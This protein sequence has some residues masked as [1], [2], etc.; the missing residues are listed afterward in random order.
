M[1]AGEETRPLTVEELRGLTEGRRYEVASMLTRG[2]QPQDP[3]QAVQAL[4]AAREA[5]A[6]ER[7]IF[8]E[9]RKLVLDRDSTGAPLR[10]GTYQ[11]TTALISHH[12][13]PKAWACVRSPEGPQHVVQVPKLG[14]EVQPSFTS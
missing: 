1:I 7:E 2:A 4:R 5:K 13:S 14:F 10:P 6:L 8:T 12:V 3:E 11:L 9:E